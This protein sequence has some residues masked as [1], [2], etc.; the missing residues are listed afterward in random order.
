MSTKSIRSA[1]HLARVR[2]QIDDACKIETGS[3]WRRR[4]KKARLVSRLCAEEARHRPPPQPFD[5][6]FEYPF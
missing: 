5:P 1:A 3:D 2:Q 6:D 4:T